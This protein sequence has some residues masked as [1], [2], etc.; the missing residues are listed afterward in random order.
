MQKTKKQHYVPK[1]LLKNFCKEGTDII[2]VFDKTRI[3]ET[4]ISS[5]AQENG[6]YDL[7]TMA[8]NISL[9]KQYSDLESK[10]ALII[11]KIIKEESIN[12]LKNE[13]F[14]VL[15]DFILCQFYRTRKYVNHV[16]NFLQSNNIPLFEHL[17]SEGN[18]KK[19]IH[20]M[21]IKIDDNLAR[22]M[23]YNF[24]YL[25][26][27][28]DKI[29]D[30]LSGM[31]WLVLKAAGNNKFVISDNPAVLNNYKDVFRET[32][33]LTGFELPN[34]QI[35]LPISSKLTLLL[36]S[37]KLIQDAKER[38]LKTLM[39]GKKTE[40]SPIFKAVVTGNAFE[41]PDSLVT[42]LNNLQRNN[43]CKFVFGINKNIKY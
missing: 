3:F 43:A 31:K 16:K 36:S 37:P 6:F 14:D 2:T 5:V 30:I 42:L 11:N 38:L 22:I 17:D 20:T 7:K 1:L 9:E 33:E 26:E 19:V 21:D 29:R 41:C 4:K 40:I 8:G 27:H 18:I 35:F 32:D 24:L 13:D 10:V 39:S 28:N 34:S 23:A 25:I 12:W 15:E